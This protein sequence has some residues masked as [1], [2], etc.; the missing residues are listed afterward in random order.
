MRLSLNR[1]QL[2]YLV[3]I[4]ML[5]DH[6]AWAFVP[7]ASALG[8][9]MHFI[10][11]LTGP[12]MAFFVAEGYIH[13]RDVRRYL[14][15]MGIFTLISWIPFSLFETGRWPTDQLGVIF[16]LFLGLLA[17]Y[18]FYNTTWSL[19]LKNLAIT[20]LLILSLLGDWPVFDVIVPLGLVERQNHSERKWR[21]FWIVTIIFIVLM[22]PGRDPW[23]SGLCNL[24]ML[25]VPALLQFCYNGEP[26]SRKPFHKWFFYI[27]YPAHLFLLYLLKM[28]L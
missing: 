9:L 2:K 3:C 5:M 10:G 20:G 15:R 1:N 24:G 16:T 27:F 22:L 19:L 23:W 26:G 8:M 12:T 13:T 7:A 25:M 21:Y 28:I 18:I 11:R 4:A 17:I 14:M 6:I